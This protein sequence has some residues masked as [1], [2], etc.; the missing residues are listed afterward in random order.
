MRYLRSFAECF[1]FGS[2]NDADKSDRKNLFFRK[3]KP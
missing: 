2:A 3:N 1:G